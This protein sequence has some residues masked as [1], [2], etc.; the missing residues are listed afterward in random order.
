[1]YSAVPFRRAHLAK[2]QEAGDAEGGFFATDIGTLMALEQMPNIWTIMWDDVPLLCGGTVEQ[3]P[4][5]HLA[6]AYLNKTTGRHMIHTTKAAIQI[7]NNAK[8]RVELTVRRDFAKG[9][10]WARLIGFDVE[11]LPGLMVERVPL[12]MPV[13]GTLKRYGP[14]GEDHIA[15]VKFTR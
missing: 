5:R 9:H 14:E 10:R 6:W 15:Y 11:E 4:G 1:M 2:I 12:S 13:P 8:G 7:I 3:W